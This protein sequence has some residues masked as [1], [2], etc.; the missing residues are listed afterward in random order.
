MNIYIITMLIIVG[1]WGAVLLIGVIKME[2][3]DKILE[4]LEKEVEYIQ[5]VSKIIEQEEK[6]TKKVAKN[7]KK[8]T[9]KVKEE[10]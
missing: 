10:N 2:I 5:A 9:K 8:A 6:P 3:E 1:I 7:S 4:E